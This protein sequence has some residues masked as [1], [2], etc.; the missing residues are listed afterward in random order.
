MLLEEGD[1]QITPETVRAVATKLLEL[2]L[3]DDGDFGDAT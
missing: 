1:T 2:E 3:D